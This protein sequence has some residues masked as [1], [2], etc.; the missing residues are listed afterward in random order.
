MPG[1]RCSNCIAFGSECTRTYAPRGKEAQP[2]SAS[3]P[4]RSAQEHVSSIL[5]GSQEYTAGD[6]KIL[7]AL[8]QYARRLEE[9]LSVTTTLATPEDVLSVYPSPENSSSE[10]A[11]N[12]DSEDDGVLFDE[13]VPSEWPMRQIVR[14]NASERFYGRTSSI[15]FVKALM[16]VRAEAGDSHAPQIQWARPQFWSIKPWEI[17]PEIYVPQIFPEPDLLDA[18]IKLFFLH[19]NPLVFVLHAPTFHRAVAAGLHLVDQDFG[20]VVL[21]VCAVGAKLS[22]DPRALL[23][24]TSDPLSAGW[25]W[26]SQV[27]PI[28]AS[29]A[30]SATLHQLQVIALTALYLG[31]SSTPES[32]WSTIGAGLRMATDVGAHRRMRSSGDTIQSEMYKRVFWILLLSDAIMST[33]LGRPRGAPWQDVDLDYPT[34]LEGE[35]V[36]CRP[37]AACLIKLLQI[38]TRVQ[39]IIYTTKDW[40]RRHEMVAELD[41]ALNQWADSIPEELRW[42]PN[43]PNPMRLNQSANLYTTYYHTQIQ[44]HRPFIQPKDPSSSATSFPSLAI[45]WNAARS[46]G[47]VM[48]MQCKNGPGLVWSPHISSAMFDSATVLLMSGFHRSRPTTDENVLRCLSVLRVYESRFQTAGRLVD[49]LEGMLEVGKMSPSLKRGRNTEDDAWSTVTPPSS[50]GS[51][52]IAAAAASG[53]QARDLR[54]GLPPANAHFDSVVE[55]QFYMPLRT[56]DLGRLPTYTTTASDVDSL[57]FYPDA[58]T[59]LQAIGGSDEPEVQNDVALSDQ[60]LDQSWEGWRVYGGGL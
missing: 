31:S 29:F 49:I 50:N 38:Q 11:S 14:H 10:D 17:T 23:E 51:I 34:P 18:F 28:P 42:D 53:S 4:E 52:D 35:D 25:R 45:C 44:L 57:F 24:G 33:L 47:H 21:V 41:S 15:N 37:Y 40:H 8:A 22:D 19:V 13:K 55:G 54:A 59:A 5:S 36:I 27:R 43:Q 32:C 56:E 60:L 7:V 6:Y 20:S 46:C 1:N 30:Q 16:R 26:W 39:D 48:E 2:K 58:F 3:V 9:A 12:V